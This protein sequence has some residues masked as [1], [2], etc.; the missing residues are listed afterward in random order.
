MINASAK[1]ISKI[2]V[3][4][5]S[6]DQW[7]A[8]DT[9]KYRA[10]VVANVLLKNPIKSP[11]YD[12]YCLKGSLP[13]DPKEDIAKR[14]WTDLT[15][16]TWAQGDQGAHAVVSLYRPY[17]YDKGRKELYQDGAYERLK[18]E[19][20]NAVPDLLT[21][22]GIDPAGIVE[23]RLSRWGHALPAA[24]KGL[25]ADGTLERAAKP[26]GRVFFGQQ[27]NWASPC[28]ESSVQSATF[29]ADAARKVAT[30]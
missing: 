26:F 20:Q 19:F 25:I 6:D 11:G 9:L 1:F 23:I 14:V 18:K 5:L 12:V 28:F 10:Y 16:A 8:M 30:G 7:D 22:M 4:G 15:Y 2:V 13:T 29:A 3:S 27:D 21:S 24:Q 17:A